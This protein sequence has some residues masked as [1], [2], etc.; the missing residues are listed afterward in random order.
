MVYFTKMVPSQHYLE[1]HA[2]EVPWH[3]VVAVIF[4]TKSPRKKGNK[5]EIEEKGYYI[6]FEIKDRIL[7]VINAKRDRGNHEMS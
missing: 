5:Y 2:S 7:Y 4:R 3:E 6:L 1:M